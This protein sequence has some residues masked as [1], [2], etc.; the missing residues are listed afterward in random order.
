MAERNK[1]RKGKKKGKGHRPQR[2]ATWQ[3][4]SRQQKKKTS[5]EAAPHKQRQTRETTTTWQPSAQALA[6]LATQ[7]QQLGNPVLKPWPH[8]PRNN[9]SLATQ[10]SSPGPI[11]HATTTA[12]QP[13]AQALAPLATQQQPL[14]TPVLKPWPH[15][16]RNNNRLATQCASPGPIGHA[17]TTA[18]HP[19]AQALAP[20]ATQQQ[21]LGNPVLKPWPHWPRNN[22]RLATQCTSPGSISHETTTAWQ[23]SAQALAPL[24]TEGT[25]QRQRR[26]RKGMKETNIYLNKPAWPLPCLWPFTCLGHQIR[27]Q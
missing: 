12:W 17:T 25:R 4:E 7:Q 8:W 20:L 27:R 13:S 14:G 22:N 19:S 3:D 23:P 21:P 18:W 5:N 11:G 2:T 24:A 16:P 9:N 6:P 1:E 10:C 15:W 26:G